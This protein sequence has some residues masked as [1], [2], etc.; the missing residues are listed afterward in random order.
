MEGK[1]LEEYDEDDWCAI[2]L[3]TAKATV[4]GGVSGAAIYGLTNCLGFSAPLAANCV[5]AVAGI[6][7]L[8]IGFQKL[9]FSVADSPLAATFISCGNLLDLAMDGNANSD[10]RLELSIEMARAAGVEDNHLLHSVDEIDA[11]FLS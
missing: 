8:Y 11:Y 3:D 7:E 1:S 6:G 4:R 5:S 2:G 9:N 10:L